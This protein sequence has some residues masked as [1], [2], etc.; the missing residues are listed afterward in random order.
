MD[1]GQTDRPKGTQMEHLELA[2]APICPGLGNNPAR[3]ALPLYLGLSLEA[4]LGHGICRPYSPP[5]GDGSKL[6][7]FPNPFQGTNRGR[8]EHHV[9]AAN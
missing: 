9:S 6:G 8:M 4:S 7:L 5:G 1:P 3:G 2:S